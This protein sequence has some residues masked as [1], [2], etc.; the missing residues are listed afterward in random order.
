MHAF[1]ITR[2][3]ESVCRIQPTRSIAKTFFTFQLFGADSVRIA[4][5][6]HD[7][8]LR[9]HAAALLGSAEIAG[10]PLLFSEVQSRRAVA[11]CL[12]KPGNSDRMRGCYPALRESLA[13]RRSSIVVTEIHA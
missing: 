1:V 6:A 12:D 11:L 8:A 10:Q 2:S 13:L 5:I 4:R 7:V 3:V 9:L